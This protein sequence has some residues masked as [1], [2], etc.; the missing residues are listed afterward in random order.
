MGSKAKA[1]Y[2]PR[3][4]REI[5]ELARL[6]LKIGGPASNFFVFFERL[7]HVFPKLRLKIVEDDSLP[8][9]VEARA[10]PQQWLIKIRKSS[11]VNSGRVFWT[12]AHECAHVLLQHPRK[13]LSR[14]WTPRSS[15]PSHYLWEREADQ[16][17]IKILM[18]YDRI[19]DCVTAPEIRG[20]C[21]TSLE[22]SEYRLREIRAD[23]GRYR[24]I[25]ARGLSPQNFTEEFGYRADIEDQVAALCDAISETLQA[26]SR[27]GI[28]V[29]P[30]KGNIFSTAV[31][32][33]AAADLLSEAYDSVRRLKSKDPYLTAASLMA[34]IQY[35]RPIRPIGNLTESQINEVNNDCALCA[36]AKTARIGCGRASGVLLTHPDDDRSSRYFFLKEV[37]AS[38]ERLI[39]NEATLLCLSN[40][41]NYSRYHPQA[42]ISWLDIHHIDHLKSVL[43]TL[44]AITG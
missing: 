21:G 30:Y 19:K 7:R 27:N 25:V 1:K 5:T 15:T 33:A 2:V 8:S 42:D 34:A 16:F 24:A 12:L 14:K 11:L 29:R 28:P 4:S 22:T 31:F 39:E 3:S 26:Y 6:I 44:D 10:Y 43:I 9:D 37:A 32:V 36:G 23:E 41:P 40:F 38:G 35:L 18:P 17:A 20:I 13:K